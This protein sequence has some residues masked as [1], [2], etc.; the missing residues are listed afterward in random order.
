MRKEEYPPR[1]KK[2]MRSIV[3][4]AKEAKMRKAL[5]ELFADFQEWKAGSIDSFELS[6]RI[7]KFH[8]G[9]NREIYVRYTSRLDLRFL[10]QYAL[11]EKLIHEIDVPDEV[12][13]YLDQSRPSMR[14][15]SGLN[16]E[17]HD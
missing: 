11:D 13:P 16:H 5:D 4:I 1:I 14:F 10:I 8:N 9:P 6:D 12:R 7:H 17:A 15:P 3:G 2:A